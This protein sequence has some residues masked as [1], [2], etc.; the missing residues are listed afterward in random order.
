ML[1]LSRLARLS[2]TQ[3][4]LLAGHRGPLAMRSLALDAETAACLGRHAGALL[5]AVADSTPAETL[6]LLVR[7][8]GPL[9]VKKLARL[10][11]DQARALA[12]QPCRHG[13]GGLSSLCLDDVEQLTPQV[14]AILATHRAGGLVLG[15]VA[16]VTE[17][18][19]RELVRH[20]LLGLDGV[21]SLTDRAAGILATHAGWSLSLQGL[22]QVG[23]AGLALLRENPRIDLPRRLVEPDA[24]PAP[25][26]AAG[27]SGAELVA[28]IAAIAAAG[29]QAARA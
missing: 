21:K 12:T 9:M 26:S 6:A 2:P 4:A 23:R 24:D 22:E 25:S 11:A 15:K 17:D 14:A 19:A 1:C 13:I 28:A 7:H 10:D 18:V 3:A 27:R 29:G 20:P 5:V 16:T 8:G